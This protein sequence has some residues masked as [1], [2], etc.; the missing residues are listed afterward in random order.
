MFKSLFEAKSSQVKVQEK[1]ERKYGLQ[2]GSAKRYGGRG[3]LTLQAGQTAG[4]IAVPEPF[5]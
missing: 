4:G 1:L 3:E 5:A 2:S